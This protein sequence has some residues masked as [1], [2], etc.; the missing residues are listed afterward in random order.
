MDSVGAHNGQVIH[1]RG[2]DHFNYTDLQF[3]TPMLKY[4]G[5]TGSINGYRGADIVNSYVLDFF[6]KHLKEKG[7]QLLDDA[8]H[9]QYPEIEFQKATLAAE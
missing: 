2:T 7:G 9:P 8:P 4:T 5:M 1:I 3:Y 6:T